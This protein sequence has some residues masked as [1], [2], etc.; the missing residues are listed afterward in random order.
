V[1]VAFRKLAAVVAAMC[2]STAVAAK[3]EQPPVD[4]GPQP[5]LIAA[6]ATAEAT[7]KSS[8]FDPNSA[9]FQ[10]PFAWTGGYWK[11]VLQGKRVGWWTCGLV[12]AKNRMGGYVGFQNFV[13]VFFNGSLTH[14]EVGT[15]GDY[16]FTNLGCGKALQQ[17]ALKRAEAV[18]PK[19][20]PTKPS[21][22]IFVTPVPDGLYLA[23]VSAGYPASKAGIQQGMVISA[24]NG[25]ALKGLPATTAMQILSA[26]GSDVTLTF[27]GRGD[28]KLTKALPTG[29]NE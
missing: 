20:D 3:K 5:D 17:G 21:L 8:L 24:I 9:E 26:T 28:I 10:W 18:S 16:D 6:Q 19:L 23:S 12:N 13:V 22:G 1:N 11:P 27:I 4:P 15:G 14:Y 29:A 7:I 25:V 2:F